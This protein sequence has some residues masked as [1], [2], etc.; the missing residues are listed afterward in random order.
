VDGRSTQAFVYSA[1]ISPDRKLLQVVIGCNSLIGSFSDNLLGLKFQCPTTSLFHSCFHVPQPHFSIPASTSN[2]LTVWRQR[3][4]PHSP[5][6]ITSCASLS[7]PCMPLSMQ[8]GNLEWNELFRGQRFLAVSRPTY[9]LSPWLLVTFLLINNAMSMSTMTP[10]NSNPD[11]PATTL[12][13]ASA[14]L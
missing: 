2:W 12:L 13:L 6:P 7:S 11:V 1:A 10:T 3:Y 9:L 4:A 14:P 8:L 5:F